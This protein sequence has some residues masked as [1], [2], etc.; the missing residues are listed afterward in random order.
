MQRTR[1]K[2]KKR[3]PNFGNSFD[4]GTKLVSITKNITSVR[5]V[6][7]RKG[8][9]SPPPFGSNK[10]SKD[11]SAIAMPGIIIVPVIVDPILFIPTLNET[12]VYF[13]VG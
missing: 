8:I 12:S 13:P 7:E 10:Q 3:T 9:L 5:M 1:V 2:V 6:V 4:K 11:I